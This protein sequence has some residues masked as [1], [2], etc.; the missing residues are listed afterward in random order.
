MLASRQI[1]ALDAL[2]AS[3]GP[4]LVPIDGPVVAE[5]TRLLGAKNKNQPDRALAATARVHGF[6]L[7]TRNVEDLRGCGVRVLDPF[8]PEPTIETV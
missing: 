6:V 8:R 7:V 4:R 5:W 1:A 2:E 3:Y